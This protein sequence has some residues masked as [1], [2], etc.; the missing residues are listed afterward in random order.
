MTQESPTILT[1]AMLTLSPS[2]FN[3]VRFHLSGKRTLFLTIGN[4]QY[5]QTYD[6]LLGEVL[7]FETPCPSEARSGRHSHRFL[8]LSVILRGTSGSSNPPDIRRDIIIRPSSTRSLRT[9]GRRD[10]ILPT[11]NTGA[12]RLPT[13]NVSPH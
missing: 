5:V 6:Y 10:T 4:A 12:G 11:G 7:S 1:T 3:A 8:P 9:Y 13:G 2:W